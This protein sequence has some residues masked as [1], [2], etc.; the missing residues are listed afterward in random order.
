M[1]FLVFAALWTNVLAFGQNPWK[2]TYERPKCFIE[3]Q[4]QFDAY[5][6]DH[7]GLILF[8][9]D[10]GKAKVFFG[11]KGIKYFFMDASKEEKEG[12]EDA[13][14]APQIKEFSNLN[15]HKQWERNIGKYRFKYDEVN[16]DF[17]GYQQT[18]LQGINPLTPYFSYTYSTP[19]GPYIN[20]N[21]VQGFEQIVYKEIAPGIDLT[22]A[23]HPESGLKYAL[24]VHPN[25][26]PTKFTMHFDRDVNLLNQDLHINTLF[27]DLVDHAPLTFYEHADNATIPSSFAVRD[28]RTVGFQLATYQAANTVIIDPW[29]QLPSFSSNWDCVWEC[30]KDAAGN[31]YAIGGVMPMQL[32]KYNAAGTLQWTYSTP[33]DTSNVWLGTLAV[34]NVGNSYVTAG[35]VAAIQKINSSGS[36]VW[37]NPN[38]GGLLSNDEFWSISFNCDQS[39]LVVGGTGG[40]AFSLTASIYNIDVANGNITS[41]QNVAQGST[42]G[43]PPSLQEVRAIC[44]SP[45]GKYYFLT[46]DTVG[47]INQNFSACGGSPL[48]Y[49]INNSY[50]LGYKCENYR[51]DNSGICAIKANNAFYYTQNGVNVVKRNLQT[52]A[53]LT[54]SPIPGGANT[55]ALGDFSVSNSGL[56][57]DNC[58]NVYVGSS[59]G[60]VKYD[61]NLVQLA[62]YPTNFKVYDVHVINGGDIVAVGSTGTSS[63][64]VRTGYVQTFTAGACA[65]MTTNCCDASICPVQNMCITDAPLQL[66]AATPGGT[67]SGPGVSASGVFTPSTAGVGNQTITYTLACGSE[68]ITIV[69]SPCQ[70]LTACVEANGSITVSGGVAPYTWAYFQA[71]QNTPIT[72]QTECQNCGYT[73]FFGQCLNGFTPVVSCNAPAQWVNF[74]TG[75]NATPPNGSAQVQVTDAGGTVQVFTLANLQPCNPNPCPTITLSP[76]NI[77]NATCFGLSDG[78]ANVTASGGT[79]PY[80]YQ[81]MPGNLSGSSQTGLAAGTYTIT[82]TDANNCTGDTTVVITS[83]AQ[84]QINTLNITATQCGSSNGAISLNVIG[85]S[86]NYSYAWNPNAGASST[87]QNLAGGNYSVVVTDIANGC[88]NTLQ[89]NVPTLG[90]PTLNNP[91]VTAALCYGVSN[92]GIQASAGGSTPPYQ[93]SLNNGIAQASGLFSGLAAGTYSLTVTDANG[94]QNSLNVIVTQPSELVLNPMPSVQVCSG[95]SALLSA[96]VSGGIAPYNYQWSGNVGGANVWITPSQTEQITLTV[97]D[98]N[99]CAIS[100]SVQVTIVP[101]GAIVLFIPNVFTPNADGQNDTYGIQSINAVSQEA[102]IVNRWGEVMA[103]L[104]QLNQ[105]WDGLT[106]NGKEALDG[107][108]FMKYR[109]IGL[110]GEEQ[111]GHVF[112]HLKR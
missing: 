76:S 60:V 69:V 5:Q 20:R 110:G 31:I 2:V 36:L 47:A 80:N 43:I 24:T 30:D 104:N 42:F 40:S 1:R 79:A 107:V 102:L 22:Y 88:T 108:Y 66:S 34:D 38:P 23:I 84:I 106:A 13:F 73:W 96:V 54:T 65:P 112:F 9:A 41:S 64:N 61:G 18:A 72:N 92:G 10:F 103:E 25:A 95:D 33:Y 93:Y 11:K 46:Q 63:S 50:N 86:G 105:M 4:G 53:I 37:N 15:E 27:G 51:Y 98:A 100:Q 49:K 74:A 71:A 16:L 21:H 94:C 111:Q 82:A 12:S 90:G 67:W 3:N 6:N 35:S 97:T 58:G 14:E 57:I 55:T 62:T 39:K 7:T 101:C 89:V 77:V 75:T 109:V 26:D 8:A 83:P 29:T 48:F 68:S 56:D 52:G 87:I 70:G 85:G 45:N 32:L 28:E 44:A 81:W 78:S 19:E 17:P 59:T 91:V 99:A